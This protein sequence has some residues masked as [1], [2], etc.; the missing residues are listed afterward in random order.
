MS[1]SFLSVKGEDTELT[2]RFKE[3]DRNVGLQWQLTFPNECHPGDNIKYS[4]FLNFE[5]A[6]HS[7]FYLIIETIIDQK[8][9]TQYNDTLLSEDDYSAGQEFDWEITLSVPENAY[10]RLRLF[11]RTLQSYW[12]WLNLTS[13]RSLTYDELEQTCTQL[14]Q[15]FNELSQSYTTLDD[16]YKNLEAT[17]EP[18]G[19][20]VNTRTL[21]FIFI[22]LTAVFAATTIYN[23]AKRLRRAKQSQ[24]GS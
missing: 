9:V 17:Y 20:L 1:Q 14:N 12:G 23:P 7:K 24:H 6:M 22:I 4:I 13:V 8:W 19:K 2:Y 10:G 21:M 16:K 3:G 15:S 5:S 11:A 18:F